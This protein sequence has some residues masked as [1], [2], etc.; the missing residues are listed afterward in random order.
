MALLGGLAG[1]GGGYEPLL[2]DAH[3]RLVRARDPDGIHFTPQGAEL[4]AEV[5]LE[6]FAD[7][8]E[9]PG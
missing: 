7:S 5:V 2:P 6:V 9:L 8:W 1:P 4:V 3:G